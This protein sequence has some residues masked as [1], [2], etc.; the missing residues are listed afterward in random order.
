M[1]ADRNRDKIWKEKLPKLGEEI[2][3]NA[4]LNDY[5]KA[6]KY[7][8]P[9][10]KISNTIQNKPI[11]TGSFVL[12]V[13][14]IQDNQDY[15]VQTLIRYN[16][17]ET[18]QRFTTNSGQSWSDWCMQLNTANSPLH[19][20]GHGYQ[21][22]SSGLI[23][24]WGYITSDTNDTTQH[25]LWVNYNL[26]FPNAVSYVSVNATN[27]AWSILAGAKALMNRDRFNLYYKNIGGGQGA[28]GN[29]FHWMAIGY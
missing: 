4:N 17:L 28:V 23:I 15:A 27:Y 8:C 11:E 25:N 24:Q 7:R 26:V 12:D 18:Y 13:N 29:A 22:L 10:D 6:G 20:S 14:C 1:Y 19:K 2:P 9:L 21:R 3:E 16:Q 5:R